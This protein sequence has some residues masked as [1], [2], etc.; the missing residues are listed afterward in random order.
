MNNKAVKCDNCNSE[1]I[2][3]KKGKRWVAECSYCGKSID[4]GVIFSD[5]IS[6]H[7]E[8]DDY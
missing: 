1:I 2:T 6:E 8:E 3:F 7:D 4:K 5:F